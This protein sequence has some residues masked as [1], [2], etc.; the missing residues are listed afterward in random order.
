M[1]FRSVWPRG[2]DEYST[3]PT[4]EVRNYVK[5]SLIRFAKRREREKQGGAHVHAA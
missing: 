5:A 1:L 2:L 3:E 4:Q